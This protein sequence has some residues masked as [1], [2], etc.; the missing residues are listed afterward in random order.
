MSPV[1]G[2]PNGAVVSCLERTDIGVRVFRRG[3]R[4]GGARCELTISL[5]GEERFSAPE[6]AG[7]E[8]PAQVIVDLRAG[9]GVGETLVAA[10][11]AMPWRVPD[12]P[13][14]AFGLD[15]DG[16]GRIGYLVRTAEVDHVL[17]V[18]RAALDLDLPGVAPPQARATGNWS[19]DAAAGGG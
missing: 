11:R 2:P 6:E 4:H 16:P 18:I 14:I 15:G 13:V 5:N 8:A 7:P 3:R 1:P 19:L 12:L 10:L 9:P 17:E